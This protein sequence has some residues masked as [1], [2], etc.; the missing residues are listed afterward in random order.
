M[1]DNKIIGLFNERNEQALA[2]VKVKYGHLCDK[3]AFGILNNHEDVDECVSTSYIKLWNAIPPKNP[4]SLCGYLCAIVR[5]TA[6]TA[7]EHIRRR[8][9]EQQLDELFE[10]IPDS[11]TVEG[12]YDSGV[13]SGY[14]N[15]FLGK[16][17]KKNRV[18]FT[19][20]YYFN[21]SIND[22]C[23][24]TGMGESAV[25]SSLSRTRKA[26]RGYLEERGITV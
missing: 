10:V 23:H 25:K 24:N 2:E 20:R 16:Q 15:D 7:Y 19:A 4:T 21:M 11:H 26:L 17:S 18:V 22:I 3:I 9:C 1:E 6:L 5:N 12:D 14:L 8:S 13:I